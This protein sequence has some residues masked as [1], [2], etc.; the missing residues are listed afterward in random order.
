[1][2]VACMAFLLPA[3]LRQAKGRA[4]APGEPRVMLLG[5]AW[6]EPG[7]GEVREGGGGLAAVV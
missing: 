6:Y 1:M 4:A 7:P 2:D 3:G 5:V